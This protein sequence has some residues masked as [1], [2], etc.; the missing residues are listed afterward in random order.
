MIKSFRVSALIVLLAS[1]TMPGAIQA[2]ALDQAQPQATPTPA[3]VPVSWRLQ[4][5]RDLLAYIQNIGADGLSPSSY[6]ADRLAAAIATGDEAAITPV[7]TQAFLRLAA[8]LSGGSVR[9]RSRVDW[10]IPGVGLDAA[11]QQRLMAQVVR[12]GGVAAA[13]DGLLPVHPQYAGPIWSAGAG[14]RATLGRA[15]YWS[16]CPPSPPP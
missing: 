5:A 13:L 10:H 7:A 11:G 9:G 2:A 3:P 16:T 4:D 8:D 15:T 1:P 14:C 6:S 12:V